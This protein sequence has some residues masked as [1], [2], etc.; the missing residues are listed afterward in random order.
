MNKQN[1]HWD[2]DKWLDHCGKRYR[3]GES[4]CCDG[5]RNG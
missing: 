3:G 5:N 2:L 4:K 1:Q